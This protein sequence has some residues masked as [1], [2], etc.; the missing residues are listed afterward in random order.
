E[1]DLRNPFVRMETVKGRDLLTGFETTSG[2]ANRNNWDGHYVVGA[3]NGDFFGTVPINVQV[4]NGEILQRPIYKSTIGFDDSNHPVLGIVAFS[5]ALIV[6]GHSHSIDGIN[7]TRYTNSLIMYNNFIGTTTGTNQWGTEVAAHPI[8]SWFVND[9][10]K[11]V[12]DSIVSGVG[13][14][15]I[16]KGGLVLSGH[17]SAADFL[18]S[19]TLIHDTIKIV[20]SLTPSCSRL[21]EMLGGFPRIVYNGSDFVDQGYQIENGPS[22]TYERHPRTGV[23][24]SRDSSKLYLVTVDGRQ[25]GFSIGMTLHEFARL[26]LDLGCYQAINLDGGGSTTM[27]VRGSIVNSPSEPERSVSNSLMVISSAKTD[28][29]VTSIRMEPRQIRIFS[30]DSLKLNVVAMD[31]YYNPIPFDTSLLAIYVDSSLGAVKNGNYF[32]AGRHLD[33]GYVYVKYGSAVDSIF[34]VVKVLKFVTI[35]PRAAT[36]DTVREIKFRLRAYDTDGMERV[37]DS[38]KILWYVQNSG[39]GRMDSNG[40]FRGISEG[41]TQVIGSYSNLSDTASVRVEIGKGCTIIDSLETLIGWD[42]LFLNVDTNASNVALSNTASSI[43]NASFKIYY[44]FKYDGNP[45][46]VTLTRNFPI[47]GVPDTIWIDLKSD[48]YSHIPF[49]TAVDA[50]GTEYRFFSRIKPADST[51]FISFP[52]SLENQNFTYPMTLKAIGIVLCGGVRRTMNST[53]VGTIFID[54]LRVCYPIN[55]ATSIRLPWNQPRNFYL[56]Q[57]FPNPFNPDTRITFALITYS[58][59]VLKVYDV[60]GREVSTLVNEKLQP[61]LHEVI[62][63]EQGLPSGVYYYTLHVNGNAESRKMVLVK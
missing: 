63:R 35:S 52:I 53:Y 57:N 59:V 20:I 23:G 37:V 13:N 19:N 62:F 46:Y 4:K 34:V 15:I 58:H 60:L 16:P 61:G 3:I 50:I 22:H 10:V 6:N 31:K 18:S 51:K 49:I 32:V 11:C 8:D 17:G 21:K 48:S 38:R 24:F 33:S 30:G 25:P 56:Y 41:V 43:G 27:V 28:G 47:Y 42:P 26:M 5:G 44:Q 55:N 54:N 7:E 39:V 29:N 36:V 14:M 40:V 12:V 45:S 2:M 1:V 9:T